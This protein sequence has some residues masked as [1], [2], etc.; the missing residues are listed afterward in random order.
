MNTRLLLCTGT[1]MALAG[2]ATPAMAQ[3]DATAPAASSDDGGSSDGE[4]VVTAL[5]RSQNLQDIPAAIS[6]VSSEQLQQR[7]IDSIES[8][9]SAVPNLDFGEHAGTT[10]ISIRGVGSIVDSGITEPTVATYVDGVFMPRATMGYL[11]AA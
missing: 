3:S 5:K 9:T 4:I 2:L 1:A 7:G 10:L 6:A 8:L 11:R